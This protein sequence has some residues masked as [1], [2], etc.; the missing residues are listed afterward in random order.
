MARVNIEESIFSDA[1]FIQLCVSR[2]GLEQALGS[3]VMVWIEAQKH[4]LTHGEIP[5]ESWIKQ[6]LCEDVVTCGLAER[7][8]TGIRVKG[9]DEQFGWLRQT[10]AAGK[11]SAQSRMTKHGTAKP[12]RRTNDNGNGER[13]FIDNPTGV[14]IGRYR[15]AFQRR[16]GKTAKLDMHGKTLGRIGHLL[17]DVPLD[18]ACQLIERY[19]EM[20]DQWFI[21]K[22]HDFE[23]FMENLSK[24]GISLDT[25]KQIT[26]QEAT[27]EER[28][29]GT[30]NVFQE[31]AD[32]MGFR[33]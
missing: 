14:F 25:G 10:H 29:Q 30:L 6:R 20:S 27:L 1:R 22:G 8:L 4:Y 16:Y 19:C 15:A 31:L 9:Q 24:V 26:R 3:L 17:R 12:I 32:E 23:T 2:G 21:T 18:R 5:N 28:K 13:P 7:S 33:S 11:R